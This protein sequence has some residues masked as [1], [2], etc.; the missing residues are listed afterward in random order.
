MFP[1][2]AGTPG[3]D[4]GA[5]GRLFSKLKNAQQNRDFEVK[6]C[7]AA[8][9]VQT[10]KKYFGVSFSPN[11]KILHSV[12]RPIYTPGA[13]NANPPPTKGGGG[14]VSVP[15]QSRVSTRLQHMTQKDYYSSLV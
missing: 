10:E 5:S 11:F 7:P 2:C 13:C 4:V 6:K 15:H 3:F 9:P 1:T 8:A 14:G 12:E